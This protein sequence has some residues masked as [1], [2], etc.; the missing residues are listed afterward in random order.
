MLP[1]RSE[2]LLRSLQ[3]GFTA[4]VEFRIQVYRRNQ[5]ILKL[6]GDNLLVEHNPTQSARWDPFYKQY[7]ITTH[8][9]ETVVYK[10]EEHFLTAFLS[11]EEYRIRDRFGEPGRHY[12]LVQTM[13][14]TMKMTPPLTILSPFLTS[15]KRSTQW[16]RIDLRKAGGTVQ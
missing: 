5:G 1:S 11:L 9:E 8:R 7:I 12:I 6:F 10:N 4:E 3:D 13:L 16:K 2:D 14:N 15:Q